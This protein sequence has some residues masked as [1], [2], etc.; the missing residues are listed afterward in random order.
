MDVVLFLVLKES[1]RGC[2]NNGLGE[3]RC[4][5][6]VEHVERVRGR[7]LLEDERL[8]RGTCGVLVDSPS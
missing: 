8:L 6:R 1:T 4:A 7:E 3:P 5:A 2:V